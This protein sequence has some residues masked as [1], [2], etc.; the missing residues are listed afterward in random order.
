MKRDNLE[1]SPRLYLTEIVESITKIETYTKGLSREK[2]VK[3]PLKIDAVDANLR[4]IGE[5][6]R[7]LAKHSSIKSKFYY[8]HVP[9]KMLSELRSELTHDYFGSDPNAMWNMAVNILP[10]LKPQFRKILED[11]NY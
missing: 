10:T 9:Y 6:V 2:F 8:Y 11:L 4:N 7:V 5:A 1:R 3:D